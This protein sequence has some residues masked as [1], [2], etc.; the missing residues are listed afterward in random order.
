MLEKLLRNEFVVLAVDGLMHLGSIAV[1]GI[2]VVLASKLLTRG[3]VNSKMTTGVLIAILLVITRVFLLNNID[4][5]LGGYSTHIITGA[6]IGILFLTCF[7]LVYKLIAI[8]ALGTALSSAVIVFTQLSLAVYVPKLSLKI[9]PEGQRFAEYAGVANDRTKRLMAEAENFRTETGGLKKILADAAEALKFFTSDEEKANLSRDFASGIALYKARKEYMDNMSPEELA[10]YRKAMSAFLQ[11][12]GLAE[13][14]YSLSNLKNAKPEDLQNLASFMKDMNQV[15]GFTDELPKDGSSMANE[16]PPSAESLASMAQSLSR[17]E[18]SGEDMAKLTGL[19]SEL[20][21]NADDFMASMAQASDE[22]ASIR[23]LTANMAEDFKDVIPE[24]IDLPNMPKLPQVPGVA[25]FGTVQKSGG[26][27]VI[28]SSGYRIKK[29]AGEEDPSVIIGP[30]GEELTLQEYE[31]LNLQ[32]E[33]IPEPVVVVENF[34]ELEEL[35]PI[36]LERSIAYIP[37]DPAIKKAWVSASEAI[38]VDAWFPPTEEDGTAT[39]FIQ[40]FGL[41]QDEILDHVHK[42]KTYR[43][44]FTGIENGQV[45][46][47]ALEQTTTP[48]E[49]PAPE[50]SVEPAP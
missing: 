31:A 6:I 17:V 42:G 32:P 16:P 7:I 26:E 40:G 18:M 37:E 20:G 4:R 44:R 50:P 2:I 5:V 23:E 33:P 34:Y 3:F 36:A 25:S 24:G 49:P 28:I 39:A 19:F 22:L 10:A 45:T 38:R 41:R 1:L 9:M 47:V 14:R 8:P 27:E 13:N 11:E 12:Q 46:L 48:T 30:D 43:Y 15:Y 21:I 29:I 35:G